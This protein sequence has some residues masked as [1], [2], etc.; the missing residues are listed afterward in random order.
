ML[1]VKYVRRSSA[2]FVPFQVTMSIIYHK[3]SVFNIA[4][5]VRIPSIKLAVIADA[6]SLALSVRCQ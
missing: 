5:K 6:V 4:Y 1:D 3:T 2:D